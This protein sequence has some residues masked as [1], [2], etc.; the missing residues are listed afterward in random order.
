MRNEDDED[1]RV[2]V[3][4][5]VRVLIQSIQPRT[6]SHLKRGADFNMTPDWIA[7]SFCYIY[8]QQTYVV[9]TYPIRAWISLEPPGILGDLSPEATIS[10]DKKPA[11]KEKEPKAKAKGR[12]I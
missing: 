11:A 9:G 2:F 10:K 4:W 5:L 1:L 8:F 6:I 3:C 7:A 12:E